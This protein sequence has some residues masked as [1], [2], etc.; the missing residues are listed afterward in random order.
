MTSFKFEADP[1]G[2][3]YV[4]M[5]HDEATKNHPGGVADV[6]STENIRQNV[7]NRRC[8]RRI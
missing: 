8:E 3:N 2:R 6:S 5:A 7:Q 4:T 1:T